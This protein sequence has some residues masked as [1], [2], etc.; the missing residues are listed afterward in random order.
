MS[1]RGQALALFLVSVTV[2]TGLLIV[3]LRSG[4][5]AL[6]HTEIQR[7]CDRRVLDLAALE[8]MGLEALGKINPSART[9]VA[10]RRAID[11][12]I[13]AAVATPPLWKTLPSLYRTQ[14]AIQKIQ[15]QIDRAQKL[16][17]KSTL[18]AVQTAALRNPRP[19]AQALSETVTPKTPGLPHGSRDA[20]IYHITQEPGF[21]TDFGAPLALDG[22]F[23][24]NQFVEN[25]IRIRSEKLVTKPKGASPLPEMTLICRAQ[26]KMNTLED[27][28]TA[29]LAPVAKAL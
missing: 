24:Q 28:W 3:I 14:K 9:V 7:H 18:R 8:G 19:F 26:I 21:E 6:K 5:L 2:L 22:D 15:M 29:Q 13:A 11:G 17:I 27:K 12:A 10:A 23:R 25:Q 16:I 20:L 1:M 4:V